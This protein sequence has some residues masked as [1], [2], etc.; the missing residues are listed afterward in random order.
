M[1]TIEGASMAGRQITLLSS[2]ALSNGTVKLLS[3]IGGAM[4]G[5]LVKAGSYTLVQY[6]CGEPVQAV[7]LVITIVDGVIV[8]AIRGYEASSKVLEEQQELLDKQ[9]KD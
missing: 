2:K 8:G 6:C 5:G 7:D 1:L 4:V 3:A 9:N